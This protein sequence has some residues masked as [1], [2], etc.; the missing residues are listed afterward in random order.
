MTADPQT[1]RWLSAEEKSES[2][3]RTA[4][5]AAVLTVD[6]HRSPR[7]QPN[8][9]GTSRLHRGRRKAQQDRDQ[10]GSRQPRRPR[11]R[12]HLFVEQHLRSG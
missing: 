12:F 11:H 9:E 5:C 8:Q 4:V 1:A 2:T 3:Q 7:G 6:S 10:A